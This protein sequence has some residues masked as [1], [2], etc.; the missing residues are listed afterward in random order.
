M[1]RI[2]A[3][4]GVLRDA[5]DKLRSIV[6]ARSH[7]EVLR[8]VRI[9]ARG[10][11][12]L[13]LSGTDLDMWITVSA[14]A[15]HEALRRGSGVCVPFA[16]LLA[17]VR[18]V[19]REKTISIAIGSNDLCF[20]AGETKVRMPPGPPAADFP[21]PK[22]FEAPVLACTWAEP[23]R[24]AFRRALP[25][26][27]REETR[28]YLNG[29]ALQQVK[30][31]GDHGAWSLIATDGHRLIEVPAGSAI[32]DVRLSGAFPGVILPKVLVEQ[33]VRLWPGDD[34]IAV[35][36]SGLQI[37]LDL[38]DVRISSRLIDGTFPD[39]RRVIPDGAECI[40][41]LPHSHFLVAGLHLRRIIKAISRDVRRSC[42]I[43]V[44]RATVHL[45]SRPTVTDQV[46]VPVGLAIEAGEVAAGTHVNVDYLV[47][48]LQAMPAGKVT[49]ASSGNGQPLV[50][51][52]DAVPGLRALIM[53]MRGAWEV[54][55]PVQRLDGPK[56]TAAARAA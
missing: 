40:A 8:C 5:L 47:Q 2:S 35:R 10:R 56:P 32:S 36:I 45:E 37:E 9:K 49:I 38:G 31:E 20:T 27:S 12:H 55:E 42:C 13:E 46:I 39:W 23:I 1:A 30:Q 14:E 28:Y 11:R 3:T 41:A 48:L 50:F 51:T 15:S 43:V 16:P 52:S 54:G 21:A 25:F 18:T 7:I 53:P 24:G 26:I 29:V 33:I 19:P 4:A 22:E 6:D 17:F 44:D 34:A